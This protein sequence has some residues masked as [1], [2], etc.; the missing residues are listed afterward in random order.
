[1]M[2][3]NVSVL[4]KTRYL[5]SRKVLYYFILVLLGMTNKSTLLKDLLPDP[6]IPTLYSKFTLPPLATLNS[7]DFLNWIIFFLVSLTLYARKHVP[8][9]TIYVNIYFSFKTLIRFYVDDVFPNHL[10]NTHTQTHTHR[11]SFPVL[12]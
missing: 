8:F 1:M 6:L 9:F 11:L 12:Q 5:I 4:H 2:S 10:L 3:K 7:R